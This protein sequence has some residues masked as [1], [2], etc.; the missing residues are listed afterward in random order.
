MAYGPPDDDE[1]REGFEASF[2]APAESVSE[3]E[4]AG[5]SLD[6][7]ELLNLGE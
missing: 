7:D 3:K 5:A 4:E 1:A 2:E 6:T